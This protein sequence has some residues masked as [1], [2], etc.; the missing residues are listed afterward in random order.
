MENLKYTE[1]LKINKD[2]ETKL[3]TPA[4][5]IGILSNTTINT[6]KEIL[7]YTC[8]INQIQPEIE[9]GNYDNV[10]QDS[11]TY[12]TKDLVIIFYDFLNIINSVS[13]FFENIDEVKYDQLK[14]KLFNEI[15][16][17][18]NNLSQVPTVI[19]NSFSSAYF[20]AHQ[21]GNSKIVRLCN[22]LN[23]YLQEKK[24]ANTF[25]FNI[26][27]IF[28][29]LGLQ[30]SIDLRFYN[31]S[32]ALYTLPFYKNYSSS[33]ENILL[34]NTG[35]L[36]KAIIFDCDNTLWK[37][38]IGEDGIDKIEMSPQS[39]I[40]KYYNVVQQIAIFLSKKGVIVGICSKNN[41]HDVIEV[42][43][44]NKD[45][46]LTEETMVIHKINWLDKATN[47]ISIAND[48]NIGTDS[49]VFVDDSPF[50]IN[51]IKD[52]LPEV[53]TVLVPKNASEYPDLLLKYAYK[54]FNLTGNA[55]DVRKTEMY[56]Q[57]FK[58][59]QS[60]NESGSLEDYLASLDIT[61]AIAKDDTASIQRIAQL[62][63]KTNQ[64]NLTTQRYTESQ[65]EQFIQNTHWLILSM[66]VKDTFGDSG[67][68][69]VCIIKEDEENAK[70]VIIDTL[71]MSCRIIGRNIEFSFIDFIINK[72]KDLGYEYLYAKYSPTKKNAQVAS[73]YESSGFVLTDSLS[74]K[75]YELDLSQYTSK[76]INYIKVQDNLN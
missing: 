39:S 65:I 68:T 56:K 70:N 6:F 51:L 59:E 32:K 21:P 60:K 9:I 25:I 4:Y 48:L 74:D 30:Q 11:Q 64:F 45:F 44:N 62:T 57:Q 40:G 18:N 66:S 55:E 8:R 27:R 38:I 54:Y 73:F 16:L 13:V 76:K 20:T 26:E 36:K 19:F 69:G 3:D 72:M 23:S 46:L 63:Q 37:G 1:I 61:L 67:L 17:I 41:E 31:S 24:P 10:V 47:L 58:R 14:Q 35:R 5:K 49:L 22:E 34:R 12:E 29:E 28:I 33:I 43:K 42:F 53:A 15:D 7:G 2:L 71:L 50:E 75:N 52:K